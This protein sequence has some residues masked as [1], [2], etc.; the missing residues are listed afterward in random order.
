MKIL[1]DMNLPPRWVEFLSDHGIEAVHWSSVGDGRA[2]DSQILR[3][4]EDHRFAIFTHDLDFTTLLAIT[5]ASGPSVIQLRS[6]DVMPDAVG[7]QVVSV[8]STHASA[9]ETGALITVD[10]ISS[11]V[12]L[13]P[14][15]QR[16]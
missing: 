11:R 2:P 3:W 16:D 1:L 5:G 4:A 8:L 9:V 13:L 10:L 14:I 6:Q 12:R 15:R 7:A